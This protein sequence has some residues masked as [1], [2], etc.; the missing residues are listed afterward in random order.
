M[1]DTDFFVSEE[2]L[3]PPAAALRAFKFKWNPRKGDTPLPKTFRSAY[4]KAA[5]RT[6]TPQNVSEFL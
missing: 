2:R 1:S 3:K 5:C 6:I 4:P